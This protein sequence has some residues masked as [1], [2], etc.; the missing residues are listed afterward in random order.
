[1]RNPSTIAGS[2]TAYETAAYLGLSYCTVLRMA[3]RG[4]LRA[5]RKT[6]GRKAGAGCPLLFF[7]ADVDYYLSKSA[8]ISYQ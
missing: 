8:N 6:G 4:E 5:H 2:M 7:K 3:K 1:M